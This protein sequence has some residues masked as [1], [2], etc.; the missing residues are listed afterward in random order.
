MNSF[1]LDFNQK[2]NNYDSLSSDIETDVC[3]IGAGIFGLTCAYYL[4]NLGFQVTVLEKDN[5]GEKATGHTTAKITSQHNLFYDYLIT[6]YGKKF[7]SD[8][9][10]VNEKAIKNIKDIIDTENIKCDFEYQN[11]YIYTTKKSELNL[12]KKEV[13]AVESLDFPCEFVTKTG[14]PFKVEGAICFKNQAQFHPLKYLYGLCD[15]ISS[16]HGKIYTHTVVTN[17]EKNVDS[18]YIVSA[19]NATVK[20]KF[21]IVASHYPFINFPRILFS[22]NVSIYFLSYSSGY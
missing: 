6:S 10:E 14:L 15:S 3:I 17:V 13:S 11:S 5:I 19:N 8:Y 22:K 4:S 1:W 12:I 7:A 21:V 9:L 20:S 18:S 16:H 2:T